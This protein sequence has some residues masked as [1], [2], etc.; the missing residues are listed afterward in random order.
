MATTSLAEGIALQGRNTVAEQVGKMQFKMGEAE[1]ARLAKKALLDA[2]QAKE[3]EKNFKITG[4]YNRLIVPEVVKLAG[5]YTQRL[6]DL[7]SSGNPT[8]V[9]EANTLVRDYETKMVELSSMSKTADDL[10]NQAKSIDK[11][12]IYFTKNFETYLGIY[13]KSNSLTELQNNLKKSGVKNDQFLKI[14]DNGL[15]RYTGGEIVPVEKDLES[16]ISKLDR[17]VSAT[18]NQNLPEGATKI[19]TVQER[20]LTMEAAKRAFKDNPTSYGGVRPISIE[21]VVMDY[22]DTH[23]NGVLQLADRNGWNVQTDDQGNYTPESYQQVKDQMM[24]YV[25]EFA[26][27]KTTAFVSRGR[28]VTNFGDKEESVISATD[29][30]N[31]LKPSAGI[32]FTTMST[33]GLTATGYNAVVTARTVTADGVSAQNAT[34]KDKQVNAVEVMPYYVRKVGNLEV[35]IPIKKNDKHDK[36]AGVYPFITFG[37]AG[38][39]YYMDIDAFSSTALIGNKTETAI[40]EQNIAHQKKKAIAATEKWKTA[41]QSDP[42]LKNKSAD[43]I[44]NEL[45]NFYK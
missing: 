18:Y 28:S 5:E 38:K 25:S 16:E 11:N 20:P 35:K 2:Q 21:E 19:S 9:N 13:N 6:S 3:V 44:T 1:Q 22:I 24:K 27:P 32:E 30:M 42:T 10:D 41:I 7:K 15:F 4:T 17:T 40:I 26:N 45:Y 43:E 36:V 29:T 31:I 33:F 39:D 8:W 23:P 37:T 14:Q 12:K 34:L